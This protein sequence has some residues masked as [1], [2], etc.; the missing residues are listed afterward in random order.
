MRAK[1]A[2]RTNKF[3]KI[4][5]NFHGDTVRDDV[6]RALNFDLVIVPGK[7]LFYKYI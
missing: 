1:V 4:V 2:A 6:G 3:R 7:T 5:Y